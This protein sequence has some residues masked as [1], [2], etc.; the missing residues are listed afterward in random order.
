MIE[1]AEGYLRYRRAL[2]YQLN[3]DGKMLLDFARYADAQGHRG[4]LTVTLALQWATLPAQAAKRYHAHRLTVVRGFA[5]Y[6]ALFEPT[7]EIPAPRLL[8][9]AYRRST[10][11]LYTAAEQRVLLT[12]ARQLAPA[13][14]LR[15]HTYVALLG[16]LLCTGLRISE[17]LH[18][19]RDDVDWQRRLLLVKQTKFRKSRVVPLHPSAVQALRAY[20]RRRD[21]LLPRAQADRFFLSGAGA[22][23]TYAAVRE[24][25]GELRTLLPV[26]AG[27]KRPR[28]HDFRHTF[29]C[30]RLLAWYR[31]GIDVD[32]AIAALATYLGHAQV[33]D[34]YWYLTA[35]P[36][37]LAL[38]ADRFQHGDPPGKGGQR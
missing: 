33:T 16:L 36:E 1:R 32:H 18:L 38:A 5:R 27:R 25:F 7:T 17:A 13:H 6:C 21:Q 19:G 15:P 3:R 34:T 9:P 35:T 23:L 2:G 26:P 4:P 24:T 28:L 14:G 22:A 12:A 20:A 10:P 8:G 31:E 29:A 11:Y 37:L 30:Q